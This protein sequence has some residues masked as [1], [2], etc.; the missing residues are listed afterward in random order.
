MIEKLQHLPERRQR[1]IRAV[2]LS[3]E[4]PTRLSDESIVAPLLALVAITYALL[5]LFVG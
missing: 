2:A 5:T 3:M 1:Y 4:G